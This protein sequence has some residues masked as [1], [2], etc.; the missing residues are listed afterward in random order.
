MGRAWSVEGLPPGLE[1]AHA[2]TISAA[3]KRLEAARAAKDAPA[4]KEAAEAL[5]DALEARRY[6]VRRRH[7][8]AW[9]RAH[10]RTVGCKVTIAEGEA[11]A[12]LAR[13]QHTS[14]DALVRQALEGSGTLS[15]AL[16]MAGPTVEPT[17]WP[18]PPEPGQTPPRAPQTVAE[19]W[20][21]LR[22]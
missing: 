9:E 13:R 22:R 6:T 5:R 10:R 18:G 3:H 7:R 12:A 19:W 1:A 11:L 17:I 4:I 14:I 15:A 21:S 8:A 16:T 2:A 20:A